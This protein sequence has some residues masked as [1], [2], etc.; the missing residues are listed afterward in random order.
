MFG[1]KRNLS[2]AVFVKPR[3]CMGDFIVKN[4]GEIFF[5]ITRNSLNTMFAKARVYCIE[6]NILPSVINKTWSEFNFL[7]Q[8]RRKKDQ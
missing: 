5:D 4:D 6:D 7:D 3:F 8:S 1:I 2:K